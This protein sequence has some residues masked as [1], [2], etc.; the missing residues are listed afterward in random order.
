MFHLGF[1]DY[2]CFRRYF[3]Q[4]HHS[5]CNCNPHLHP[6]SIYI[7]SLFFQ[8]SS[9][10]SQSIPKSYLYLA[11]LS[12]PWHLLIWSIRSC[13]LA[14]SLLV[15][16]SNWVGVDIVSNLNVAG[17]WNPLSS[18]SISLS[19]SGMKTS[20]EITVA[21]EVKLYGGW[22]SVYFT[23]C[24]LLNTAQHYY[25]VTSLWYM[26]LPITSHQRRFEII[27]NTV[28]NLKVVCC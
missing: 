15:W 27:L 21:Q 17:L 13:T 3:F 12:C 22:C 2:H 4:T 6:T 11:S 7:N 14:E 19:M 8:P 16:A 20:T 9:P 24:R 10:S 23:C 25:D 26:I 18:S 28:H 1:T 5:N